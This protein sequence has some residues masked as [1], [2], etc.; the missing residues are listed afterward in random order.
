MTIYE[1]NLER[2]LVN[3]SRSYIKCPSKSCGVICQIIN[4]GFD[5][6]RCRCGYQFCIACKQEPHFPATCNAY[7][8]Y[9]DELIKNG[10]ALFERNS[11]CTITGRHCVSCH[12]FIEKNG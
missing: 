6:V 11:K 12:N 7:R 1:R 5:Y 10:H 8:V 2:C 4:S 9:L 3:L